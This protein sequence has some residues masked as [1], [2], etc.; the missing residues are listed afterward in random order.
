MIDHQILDRL[1][2][3]TP[4][5]ITTKARH[6]FADS[7]LKS[8]TGGLDNAPVRHIVVHDEPVLAK[9]MPV[10]FQNVFQ[11]L[12]WN[13]KADEVY[14]KPLV[15][16]I[17]GHGNGSA[18]ALLLAVKRAMDE[19]K[20]YGFIHLDDHVYSDNFRQLLLKGLAALESY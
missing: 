16:K 12:F 11:S 6:A 18:T 14:S 19:Q 3:L 5:R 9:F 4:S 2:I 15:S 7:S 17:P 1:A 8:L 13:S 20:E 10:Y